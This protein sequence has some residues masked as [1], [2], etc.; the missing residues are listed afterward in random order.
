MSGEPSVTG[1]RRHQ[2]ASHLD[3]FNLERVAIEGLEAIQAMSPTESGLGQ[4]MGKFEA[5]H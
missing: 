1:E 4:W 5:R 2:L 3:G